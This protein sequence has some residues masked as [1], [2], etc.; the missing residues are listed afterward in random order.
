MLV[1]KLADSSWVCGTQ[2]PAGAVWELCAVTCA[3]SSPV[4]EECGP[5]AVT[6]QEQLFSRNAFC[7]LQDV[8]LARTCT[9]GPVTRAL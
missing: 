2:Q 3:S 7:N 6:K 5:H 8:R 4:P 1:S 9:E